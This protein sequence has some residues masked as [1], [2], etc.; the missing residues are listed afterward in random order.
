MAEFGHIG[1]KLGKKEL[2]AIVGAKLSKARDM[3]SALDSGAPVPLNP[4]RNEILVLIGVYEALLSGKKVDALKAFASLPTMIGNLPIM[5]EKLLIHL[6]AAYTLRNGKSI[7]GVRSKF[8]KG[9]WIDIKDF[10]ATKVPESVKK[11]GNTKE[12]IMLEHDITKVQIAIVKCPGWGYI[13]GD[14]LVWKHDCGY[15]RLVKEAWH[16]LRCDDC[17][18]AF[19]KH[20]GTFRT[21]GDDDI[22]KVLEDLIG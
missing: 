20:R 18:K 3:L 8:L 13:D 12:W 1:T 19:K 7:Y 2:K 9:E 22:D 4:K 15:T 5:D 16:K 11:K 14:N 10:V 6:G 21:T 17:A